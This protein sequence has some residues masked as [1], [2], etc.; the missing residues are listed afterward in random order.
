MSDTQLTATHFKVVIT[1]GKHAKHEEMEQA[2]FV[3]LVTGYGLLDDLVG[4]KHSAWLGT[5]HYQLGQCIGKI[6]RWRRLDS[7]LQ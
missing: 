1:Q 6:T 4:H 3:R 2:A 5:D 7:C